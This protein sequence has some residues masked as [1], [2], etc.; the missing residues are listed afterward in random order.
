MKAASKKGKPS[1]YYHKLKTLWLE[2]IEVKQSTTKK[3]G[4]VSEKT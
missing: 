1:F 4:E 3:V 2:I